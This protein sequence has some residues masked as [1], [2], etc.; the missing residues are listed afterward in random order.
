MSKDS[1]TKWCC[2]V[3]VCLFMRNSKMIYIQLQFPKKQ[4]KIVPIE[5]IIGDDGGSGKVKKSFLI[6]KTH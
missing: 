4:Q 1:L 5:Y 6:L 3:I 2:F